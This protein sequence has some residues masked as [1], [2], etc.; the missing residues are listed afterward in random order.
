MERFVHILAE[1][2]GAKEN[3][4]FIAV[5]RATCSRRSSTDYSVSSSSPSR[6]VNRRFSE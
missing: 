1:S 2:A 3:P 6:F 4:L 5:D